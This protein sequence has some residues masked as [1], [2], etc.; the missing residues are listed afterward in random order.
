MGLPRSFVAECLCTPEHIVI[1][2]TQKLEN[3]IEFPCVVKPRRE[4]S[5]IG[6]SIVEAKS[7]LEEAVNKAARF[8]EHI[9]VEKF[10]K[11]RELTVGVLGEKALPVVEIV[12]ASGV[13]D[14]NAKYEADSTRYIV[15]AELD[16]SVYQRVQEDG[17]KAHSVLGC[18]GFSRVDLRLSDE[19]EVFI[20]EV[21]T[22]PGLTER[23]LLPMAAKKAGLDFSQLC[24]NM[25]CFFVNIK[26]TLY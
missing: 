25:L 21:N 18:T 19:G 7:A 11:G 5:S 4:G 12:P 13:Y 15:P 9:I 16:K 22:I 8:S 1:R 23:S 26:L 10:V 3:N 20:L 24:V 14:F 17:Y 6:L 2:Q